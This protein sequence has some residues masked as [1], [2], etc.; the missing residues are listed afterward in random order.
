MADV[1]LILKANNQDYVQKM[2]QAQTETQKVYDISEKGAKREKG[3]IEDIEGELTKLQDKEKR[4][5]LLRILK[6]IIRK[7]RKLKKTWKSMKR[8]EL[9]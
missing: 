8:P 3:L 7:Y 2:K 1:T 4:L 9:M 6:N 5:L